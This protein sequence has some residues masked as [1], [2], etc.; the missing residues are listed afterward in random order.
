MRAHGESAGEGQMP[1]H[2]RQQEQQDVGKPVTAGEEAP[3]LIAG[4]PGPAAGE[5][6]AIMPMA[7]DES[8]A[9]HNGEDEILSSTTMSTGSTGSQGNKVRSY[10]MKGE[11]HGKL[12]GAPLSTTVAGAPTVM[13][14]RAWE[15]RHALEE[16]GPG[17]HLERMQPNTI[18]QL[19]ALVQFH[20]QTMYFG[21]LGDSIGLGRDACA[22][23]QADGSN[24]VAFHP[25]TGETNAKGGV[26]TKSAQEEAICSI[27]NIQRRSILCRDGAGENKILSAGGLGVHLC[28][29][30][31]ACRASA[32]GELM[33]D[34]TSL[35]DG[36]LVEKSSLQGSGVDRGGTVGGDGEGAAA[37]GGFLPSSL[38]N[39]PHGLGAHA[40]V[41]AAAVAAQGGKD[42]TAAGDAGAG[43]GGRLR[44]TINYKT[45][46]TVSWACIDR[47]VGKW[48]AE[49]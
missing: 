8:A 28:N 5:T 9:M 40:G 38:G 27:K 19:F 44:P 13:I 6:A 39:P 18:L 34:V 17:S 43:G 35:R 10:C 32:S 23:L 29:V 26:A 46:S 25:V 45:M 41:V 49:G 20:R 12:I 1:P 16:Y 11:E 22:P 14:D 24:L 48:E 37:Q 7:V 42:V 2:Q 21:L 36:G 47:R 30:T 4:A 33:F 15:Y 31:V 3:P